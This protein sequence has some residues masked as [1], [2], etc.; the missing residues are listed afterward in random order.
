M[1]AISASEQK[2]VGHLTEKVF[3]GIARRMH[4]ASQAQPHRRALITV[5]EGVGRDDALDEVGHLG[6]WCRKGL[7][8][9]HD[10]E[11]P[12]KGPSN[13]GRRPPVVRAITCS[14]NRAAPWDDATQ[15]GFLE[16]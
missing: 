3:H 4:S 8:I 5:F 16:I 6:S 15:P 13:F 12:R 10:S 2:P 7:I 14:W 11:R 1:C 9:E